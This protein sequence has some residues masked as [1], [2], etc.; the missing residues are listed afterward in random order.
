MLNRLAQIK[1]NA[2]KGYRRDS[3]GDSA[4]WQIF[5]LRSLS[6]AGVDSF[7]GTNPDCD[8]ETRCPGG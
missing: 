6:L 2:P 1:R 4:P 5:A 7:M 8:Y 3:F